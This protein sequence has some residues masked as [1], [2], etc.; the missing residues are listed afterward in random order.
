MI[1]SASTN[2]SE[3]IEQEM[4][5]SDMEKEDDC[6]RSISELQLVQIGLRK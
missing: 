6:V 5:L 3:P 2:N 4:D 1:N